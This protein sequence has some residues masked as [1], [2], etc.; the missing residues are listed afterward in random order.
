MEKGHADLKSRR[1]SEAEQKEEDGIG[2][3]WHPSPVTHKKMAQAL[4]ELLRQS[5]FSGGKA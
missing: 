4:S 1:V 3:D 2:T 5:T